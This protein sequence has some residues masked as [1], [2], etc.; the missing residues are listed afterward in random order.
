MTVEYTVFIDVE[1]YDESKANTQ[2]DDCGRLD[3]E[4]D[5]R[6]FATETEA[7]AFREWIKEKT[8]EY[9]SCQK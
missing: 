6:T 2:M 7:V 8:K 5:L 1:W 3:L 9:P 4:Y